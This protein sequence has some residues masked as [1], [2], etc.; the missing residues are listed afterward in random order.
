MSAYMSTLPDEVIL[1]IIEL[2]SATPDG[3]DA[4]DTAAIIQLGTLC[5]AWLGPSIRVL[6]NTIDIGYTGQ[7]LALFG[8]LGFS[9]PQYGNLVRALDTHDV[10]A[11]GPLHGLKALLRCLPNLKRMSVSEHQIEELSEVPQWDRLDHLIVRQ[12][13]GPY[14]QEQ[15]VDFGA[16]I[17]PA[18][19][20]T[21]H[22]SSCRSLVDRRRSWAK[23]ELPYLETLI[24][25]RV[26]TDDFG[27]LP[28]N[29][30]DRYLPRMTNLRKFQAEGCCQGPNS[31]GMLMKLIKETSNTLRHL[32]LTHNPA[33][34]G[35]F[36]SSTFL[37]QLKKLEIL[38]YIGQVHDFTPDQL[39]TI[40]PPSIRW[41]SIDYR[42]PP[43]FGTHLLQALSEETFLPNLKACPRL[44][45]WSTEPSTAEI[46]Q[47]LLKLSQDTCAH[48]DARR[49]FTAT[50][51]LRLPNMYDSESI[52]IICLPSPW[53]YQLSL[54]DSMREMMDEMLASTR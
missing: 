28:R 38:E 13:E 33:L 53:L 1:R 3:I 29:A 24:L 34:G 48:M 6:Y 27:E 42:G 7:A 51:G 41:F 50:G 14:S 44:I 9:R 32:I 37:P 5:K 35:G 31:E 22:F 18:S 43:A 23:F 49:T 15:G 30:E 4:R 26:A 54:S 11:E 25:D 10:F 8:V 17:F 52:D 39:K 19:M 40:F 16:F 45:C 36:I 2:A 21:L 47:P 12:S 20:R 46:V